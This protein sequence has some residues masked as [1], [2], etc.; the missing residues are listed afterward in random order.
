MVYTT[1]GSFL[2][3]KYILLTW[4]TTFSLPLVEIDK[5]EG[6]KENLFGLSMLNL[7]PWPLKVNR[8][9]RQEVKDIEI[10]GFSSFKNIV[11]EDTKKD[12]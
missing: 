10:H 8:M 1:L 9:P 5:R 7:H 3:R 2:S 11:N 4:R 6:K 12:H